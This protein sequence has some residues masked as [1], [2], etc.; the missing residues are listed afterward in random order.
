MKKIIDNYRRIFEKKE[1]EKINN[2]AYQ[3]SYNNMNLNNGTD[4]KSIRD[5]FEDSPSRIGKKR[6][7]IIN[8]I[9]SNNYPNQQSN[10]QE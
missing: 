4:A 1:R 3:N 2:Y 8:L 10:N 7:A 9:N 5:Q 6:D